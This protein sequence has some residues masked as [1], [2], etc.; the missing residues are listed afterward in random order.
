MTGAPRPLAPSMPTDLAAVATTAVELGKAAKS[1]NTRRAYDADWR[2]FRAW[3]AE[4]HLDPLPASPATVGLYVAAIGTGAGARSPSTI[5]RALAGI[6]H[7]HRMK[8]LACDRRHPAIADVLSGLKRTRRRPT[9]QAAALTPDLMFKLLQA[10]GDDLPGL[11]DRAILLLGYCGALR[12]SELVA[13]DV[14]HMK[15]NRDGL[16]LTLPWSKGDQE[17]EGTILGI[18]CAGNADLCP[19]QAIKEWRHYADIEDGP[20]FRRINRWG[21]VEF[22]RL[23]DR[24]IALIIKKRAA[25]AGLA[26]AEIVALSGHSLRAGF[27]TT[28]YDKDVPEHATQRH[29]RHKSVATTRRYNRMVSAFKGNPAKGLLG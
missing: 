20:L 15:E 6:A 1:A 18:P 14:E 11:R 17:G 28:A 19:V 23:S 5:E 26:R 29:A 4:N 25:A 2:A 12:R 7:Q 10:C 21:T 13:V 27:V 3:C 8:G 9:K 16:L 22:D 24:A